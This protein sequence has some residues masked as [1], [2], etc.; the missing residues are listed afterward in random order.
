MAV[1][2][3]LKHAYNES[4]ES[5]VDRWAQDL[6][7]RFFSGQVYFERRPPCDPAQI[8]RF[9]RVLGEVYVEQ[10]FRLDLD[11]DKGAPKRP[12]LDVADGMRL[13]CRGSPRLEA[14]LQELWRR[15]AFNA[16]VG[17]A[18]DHAAAQRLAPPVDDAAAW[19]A[20]T[21]VLVANR[22]EA[23][24]REVGVSEP[25]IRATESA[26]SFG[27]GIAANTSAY[28]QV[29]AKA[30]VQPKRTHRPG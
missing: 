25:A 18:D 16:L 8:S 17:N 19:L 5:L 20:Q 14:D 9:P 10:V 1:M 4:D 6:D 7:F 26:I 3:Y 21:S 27:P 13:W 11:A 30:S 28:E 24:L 23:A 29:V 2:L 15:M 12:Y 22:W